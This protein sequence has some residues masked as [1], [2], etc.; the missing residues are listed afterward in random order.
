M[1]VTARNPLELVPIG[2]SFAS[3]AV[4]FGA[5]PEVFGSS[6]F[7]QGWY[8]P[9][10]L[11]SLAA[12]SAIIFGHHYVKRKGR[13]AVVWVGVACGIVLLTLNLAFLLNFKI[14]QSAGF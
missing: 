3:A 14:W 2:L 5:P 13:N 4:L 6:A 9:A 1:S 10:I 7:W 8:I 12:V 11:G